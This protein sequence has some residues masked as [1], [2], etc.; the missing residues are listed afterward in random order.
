MATSTSGR[1]QYAALAILSVGAAGATGVL[2]L[3]DGD[4]FR[5]YLGSVQPVLVVALAAVAAFACLG[6]LRERCGFAIYAGRSSLRG[7]ALSAKLAVLFAAAVMV[8]DVVGRFPRGINVPP[9]Q[10]FL[11]YPVMAYVAEICFHA[12]PLALFLAVARAFSRQGGGR[13]RIWWCI[14][15]ASLVEPVLQVSL[16]WSGPVSPG[17]QIYVGVSVFAFNVIQM[18]VFQRYD[19]VSMYLF[20]LIFYGCWHIAW[21]YLRLRWLF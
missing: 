18:H 8:V 10:S 16:G 2:S 19:F 14:L 17:L 9:P 5:P 12:L 6:F 15:L 20:R 4:I 1:P 13:G 7:I 11:F 21:G 3:S